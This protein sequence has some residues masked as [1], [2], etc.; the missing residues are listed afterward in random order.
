MNDKGPPGSGDQPQRRRV[1]C[2]HAQPLD[3]HPARASKVEVD[4]PKLTFNIVFPLGDEDV[5]AAV[6]VYSNGNT[7]TGTFTGSGGAGRLGSVQFER[8]SGGSN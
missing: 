7:L 2:E 1:R 6:T 5:N 8:L 3:Q 4:G